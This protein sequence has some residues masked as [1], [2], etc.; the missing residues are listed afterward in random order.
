MI[1]IASG[2][3]A[4]TTNGPSGH[5]SRIEKYGPTVWEGVNPGMCRSALLLDDGRVAPA[6]H[7][8]PLVA[9][10]PLGLGQL[11]VEGGE[12]PLPGLLVGHRVEERV[13]REQRVAREVH[14]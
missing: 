3:S 6:Q 1:V 9:E 5:G 8:V 7:D 14:L 11:D 2:V 4:G 10:G 12:Q 13:E